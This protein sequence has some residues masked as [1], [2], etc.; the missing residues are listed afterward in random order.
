MELK[1]NLVIPSNFSP[2]QWISYFHT[3]SNV[4]SETTSFMPKYNDN[5]FT[6]TSTI[7]KLNFEDATHC[8]I[9]LI[10]VKKPLTDRTA[11]KKQFDKAIEILKNEYLQAGLFVFY[12]ANNSFR[13]SLIYPIYKG[14]KRSYSNYRRHSFYVSENLPN[15]TY[16]LQLSKYKM[17]SLAELKEMF[18]VE[19]VSD[20]F[21]QEF[22]NEYDEL[23]KGIKHLYNQEVSEQQ[24]GDFGLLFIIRIIFL[25]FVQKKGW[26]GN[27]NFIQDYL[28][29]YNPELHKNG[30]Y[31]DLLC[32]LF[33]QALNLA[34]SKKNKFGFPHIS[35]P[36][37]TYLVNMPYLN[38]GLFRKHQ[39]YDLD[40]LYITNEAIIKFIE[41]L[42]S[43]NFTLE[44]NTLYDEELELNPEFLGIIFEKLINKEYGAIYT[45]RL[46]VDFMCRISLVKYLQRNCLPS[47]KLDNLY[48]LFF[49]EYGDEG[50]QTPGE[51]TPEEAKDILD[52]L[53]QIT[54]CDPAIGSGAFAV[55]MLNILDEIECLLYDKFLHQ[56]TPN[57]PFERKKRIIFQSLYGVEVKQWAVW[58]TQLRLWIT[59]L[60]EA[61]DD[62]KNS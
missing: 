9:Y 3:N 35:E 10:Q 7:G 28:K 29:S 1:S 39:D 26:L 16:Q 50:D 20:L 49:P 52:K 45:P 13:F 58:I 56:E 43:Y 40:A 6:N 38:G 61:E 5:L 8:G 47:L 19:R 55:G 31:Q 18:S 44:E 60:I 36:Y 22:K 17:D 11:R 30:I 32:P 14:T 4:F 25:G 48:K 2:S 62:L 42:F 41:F 33:F 59:L 46:E 12:D 27:N 34:P 21:Y 54:I 23:K 53:E 37:K 57:T 15:K 24:S 51:F